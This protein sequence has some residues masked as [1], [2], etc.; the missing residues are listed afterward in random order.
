MNATIPANEAEI[1]DSWC[2]W[3]ILPYLEH[4][5]TDPYFQVRWQPSLSIHLPQSDL[6]YRIKVFFSRDWLEAFI[7]SFRNF[8][9]L[10]FRNLPLPKLLAFQ[11]TRLEEPS[12]KL[13]LKASQSE[14]S[15]LR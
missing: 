9:S 1:G 5:E 4:P 8:L 11:L 7:T 3:F 13:R 12:L 2:R 6:S 15:R 10:V 14:C